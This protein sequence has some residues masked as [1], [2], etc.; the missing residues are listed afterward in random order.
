MEQPG[1]ASSSAFWKNYFAKFRRPIDAHETSET[2]SAPLD[3]AA[4]ASPVPAE[5]RARRR[6][7]INLQSQ[8]RQPK[9][10]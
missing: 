8:S 1:K 3:A 5:P 9:V 10:D 4:P 7:R 6:E 2:A